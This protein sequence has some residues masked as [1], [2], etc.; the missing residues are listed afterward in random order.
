[1]SV[2]GNT[3]LRRDGDYAWRALGYLMLSA[4]P[5]CAEDLRELVR[6]ANERLALTDNEN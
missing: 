6:P 2:A 5:E 1:M 4:N 3:I